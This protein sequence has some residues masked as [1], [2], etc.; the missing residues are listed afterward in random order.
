[1]KFFAASVFLLS[2]LIGLDAQ[3]ETA[4][5]EQ[6]RRALTEIDCKI[7]NLEIREP[8]DQEAIANQESK[9]R[10]AARLWR[11]KGLE[12]SDTPY[13]DDCQLGVASFDGDWEYRDSPKSGTFRISGRTV[14]YI[15]GDTIPASCS[16]L[17]GTIEEEDESEIRGVWTGVCSDL[18]A[19]GAFA[20]KRDPEHT[21]TEC[22][23]LNSPGVSGNSCEL[24]D[25]YREVIRMT[26]A[27][28][29]K[30]LG[31]IIVVQ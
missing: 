16:P 23:M 28:T 12:V 1:M 27:E 3:A 17:L 25:Y 5:E 7:A 9:R 4:I 21:L 26:P 29:D 14:E 8:V 19:F 15:P 2:T 30:K 18:H 6:A 20:L 13:L 22:M 31:K 11:A 24:G 10:I